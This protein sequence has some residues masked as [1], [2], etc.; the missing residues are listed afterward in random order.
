MTQ[1]RLYDD[2][3]YLWPLFSPPEEYVDDAQHWREALRK[4]LGPGRHPVLE[5][6]SGGGHTLSHLTADF[7]VT[8]VDLSPEMLA[9]SARLN[10]GVAHHQGDMRSVRLGRTFRA[11]LI[12]DAIGYMLTEADLTATFTTA[13]AH[14]EPGGVLLISP[15]YFSETFT[16]PTVLH[17]F[18]PARDSA[19]EPEPKPEPKLEAGAEPEPEPELTVI[20]YCTDPDPADTT[21]ESVFF[22][23]RRE[24]GALRVEQDRHITGLFPADTWLKLLAEAGFTAERITLPGYEGGY[25][26]HLLAATLD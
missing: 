15:D 22:F 6:G 14:L 12:H 23:I 10:P 11:V 4:R 7:D 3:A 20:E 17:W 18:C 2:L 21:I 24:Q 26:C 25:G 8:A 16:G 5:L 9:L 1:H 13:K 19:A